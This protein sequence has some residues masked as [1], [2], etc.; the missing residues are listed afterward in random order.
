M[1]IILLLGSASAVGCGGDSKQYGQVH[2]RVAFNDQPVA[3]AIVVFQEPTQHHYLQTTTD[4][5]GRYNFDKLPGGGLPLGRY[6]ISVQPPL[7]E[8]RTGE[9]LPPPKPFPPA[10]GKFLDA[11]KSGLSLEVQL[12]SNQFD[13][14]LTK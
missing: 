3:E 11:N 8:F 5:E 7:I 2:G 13:I 6:Q 4:T 12:G 1:W 10:N 9:P 14:A